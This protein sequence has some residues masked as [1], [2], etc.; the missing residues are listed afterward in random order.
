MKAHLECIP[1]L[2]RQASEAIKMST[3]DDVVRKETLKEV[4]DYLLYENWDKTTSELATKVHRIVKKNTGNEDPYKQLKEKYN[5]AA[6]E[7]YPGLDLMVKNSEDRLLTAA[8]IAVAGNVIDLARG[9]DVDLRQEVQKVLESEFAV[10]DLDLLER[11]ALKSKNVLYLADNAGET[12]FDKVLIKELSKRGINVT[13]VVKGAPI[14]N[15]ATLQDAKI[16]GIDS[17]AAVTSTGTDSIG[18]LLDYC[19]KEFLMKF[20][21]SELVISKGQANYES[22]SDV[23]DK[24]IF[25]LL[26]V[27]CPTI[28]ED[29]GTRVGSL[30][31]K[32]PSLRG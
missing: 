3:D 9:V 10:N 26:K 20:K 23:K 24:K 16:A 8:K 25:F 32:G 15:D 2:L 19:S 12:F 6:S 13:Y 18:T 28:A 31:L 22:L 30:I 7:L 14:L 5:K 29:I 27:K 21:N 17:I 4:M 1:C 11:L